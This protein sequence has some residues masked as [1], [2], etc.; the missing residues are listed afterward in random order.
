MLTVAKNGKKE[1]CATIAK[2]VRA[3]AIGDRTNSTP[4]KKTNNPR[5]SGDLRLADRTQER[6]ANY[7]EELV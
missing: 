2:E 1:P 5:T 4:K 3:I 7:Y 6:W